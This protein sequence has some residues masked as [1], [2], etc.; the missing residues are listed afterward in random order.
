MNRLHRKR[1]IQS[2]P[3]RGAAVVEFA[4]VSPLLIMLTLGMM[5]IGR[6]VM[7]KQLLIN[8]SREGA[9]FAVLPGSTNAEVEAQVV[10]ALQPTISGATVSVDP[11]VIATAPAGTPITVAVTIPAANVSWIPHPLF[12]LNSDIHAST[13]MRRE[14]Q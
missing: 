14:G 5:E 4:L 12:T 2:A 10:E 11:P 13:T 3:R 6:V 8:A 9:R 7:V 1:R